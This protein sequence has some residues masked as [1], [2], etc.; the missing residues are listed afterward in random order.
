M[1]RALE[2]RLFV[3]F[4]FESAGSQVIF[5]EPEADYDEVERERGRCRPAAFKELSLAEAS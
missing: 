2:G 5:Y 3:P 4:R 1:K